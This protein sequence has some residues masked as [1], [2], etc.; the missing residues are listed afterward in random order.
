MLQFKKSDWRDDS[1]GKKD[2]H[3]SALS[4]DLDLVLSN[5]QPP[6]TPFLGHLML[7]GL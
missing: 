6:E 4:E 2:H 3:S 7:W 5:S 1:V